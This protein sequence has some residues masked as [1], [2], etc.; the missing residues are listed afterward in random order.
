MPNSII[1][2]P[3]GCCANRLKHPRGSIS[4]W[5]LQEQEDNSV[6]LSWVLDLA[7]SACWGQIRVGMSRGRCFAVQ[8]EPFTCSAIVSVPLFKADY[9]LFM[10]ASNKCQSA[11][12][13]KA[14]A[15]GCFYSF[16]NG[17]QRDTIC[18]ADISFFPFPFIPIVS[19]SAAGIVL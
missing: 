16:T 1:S 10:S 18:Y 4:H 12:S 13:S 19:V 15:W 5:E 17:K 7:L 11:D 8:A 2:S 9:K 6:P 3:L 14:R